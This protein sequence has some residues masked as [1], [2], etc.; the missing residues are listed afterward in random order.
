MSK[1]EQPETSKADEYWM[2][3]ALEQAGLAAFEGEVPIGAVAV[4]EGRLIAAEHNRTIQ[5]TDP[6]AHAEMLVVRKAARATGNYRLSGVEIFV[7]VEPCAMCAGVL[8]WSR[9]H[10]LVYGVRDE[11]AGAVRSRACL[12]E[13]GLFNHSVVVVEDVLTDPCREILQ[14]FFRARR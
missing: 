8:V 2:G 1:P 13:E 14:E 9:V 5:L 7:T 4:L 6:S 3:V 11:K 12:L 10:R